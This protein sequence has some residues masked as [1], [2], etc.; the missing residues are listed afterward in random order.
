MIPDK[1]LINLKILS[2]IQKNGRISRSY[3]GIISLES[4]NIYQPLK[5]FLSS[6]SRRQAVF[7][8]NSIIIECVNNLKNI[9]NS[10]YT[11][12]FYYN[13]DEFVKQCDA[14]D[15]LITELSYA[16]NGIENLKFTYQ[17]D[18][19]ISSQ[20]D[21]IIIKT[22]SYIKDFSTKL[23][24]LKSLSQI[25]IQSTHIDDYV[26]N[27][28]QIKT[29]PNSVDINMQDINTDFDINKTLINCASI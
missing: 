8:I 25:N 24:N 29:P 23:K 7:E 3:D 2:K 12:K 4:S 27:N 15:L 16:C 26:S 19:N 10:K 14:I 1:L 20:L 5:R 17:S 11:N 13:S 6:D 18:P 28:I 9:I 22:N 21:I